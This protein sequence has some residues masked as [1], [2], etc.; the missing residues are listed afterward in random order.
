MAYFS[1]RFYAHCYIWLIGVFAILKLFR[2]FLPFRCF[3][4]SFR[5]IFVFKRFAG[6]KNSLGAG[7]LQR[8]CSSRTIST[9]NEN[10]VRENEPNRWVN[11]VFSLILKY[12]LCRAE[13][14][15]SHMSR[16]RPWQQGSKKQHH[17]HERDENS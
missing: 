9:S 16:L 8:T 3:I 6:N 12:F 10:E 13:H 14:A 7:G 5:L 17:A 4:A 15:A 1:Y 2:F 11:I